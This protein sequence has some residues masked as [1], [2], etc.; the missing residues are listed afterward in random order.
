MRQVRI[1][2]FAGAVVLML[3]ST[4]FAHTLFMS[5]DDNED[6]TVTVEGMYSTGAYAAKTPVLVKDAQGKVLW[7]GE[8][9]DFGQSDV[10]KPDVPYVIVLDAGPGHS[11]SADGP[12]KLNQ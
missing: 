4:A 12:P 11:V 1:T 7:Q 2:L 3:I 6:G 5:V 8:T 9:D 10:P